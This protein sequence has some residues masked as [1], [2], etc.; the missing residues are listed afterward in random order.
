MS[1]TKK[2]S[3]FDMEGLSD[4]ANN[5]IDKLANGAG[6]IV[7]RDTPQK[8]AINTY[9]EEIQ[10]SNYDSLTKAALISNA[11]KSIREYCNQKDIVEIA[12]NSFSENANPEKIDDDWIAQFM[13]RARLVSDKEFQV[14]WGKLLA[15]ECNEVN[16]VPKRVLM[17]LSQMDREDA[18]VFK[19]LCSLS[20][21]IEGDG[22]PIIEYERFNEYKKW[23]INYEKIVN[24]VSMGL[25]E[26]ELSQLSAG[27][28][29]ECD[30]ENVKIEYFDYVY[31][32]PEGINTIKIGHII[33]TKAGQALY[34]AI[35][36]D[37]NDEFWKNYCLPKWESELQQ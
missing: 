7:N 3:I 37:K 26:C 2:F 18:I 33:F 24:L 29:V 16:S 28:V 23:G 30:S 34:K 13:D 21:E 25:I 27:Y 22:T 5:L 1:D 4:V 15:T 6:W 9:I 19:N 35:Q 10:N 14:I 8:I 17:V 12:I 36:A 11:K 20:V 32:V 31:D